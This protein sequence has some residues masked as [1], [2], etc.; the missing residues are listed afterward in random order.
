MLSS[1][2]ILEIQYLSNPAPQPYVVSIPQPRN[3]LRL[4][5]RYKYKYKASYRCHGEGRIVGGVPGFYVFDK[6]W[7]KS[8]EFY[9]FTDQ[10][11]QITLPLLT[12]I[13]SGSNPIRIRP[14]SESPVLQSSKQ[15]K[16][17]K[18]RKEVMR[19]YL[20]ETIWMNI[21]VPS[22]SVPLDDPLNSVME[23][24][25]EEDGLNRRS[26]IAKQ[27]NWEFHHYHFLAESLLGG[28]ASLEITRHIYGHPSISQEGKDVDQ[29]QALHDVTGHQYGYDVDREMIDKQWLVIPWEEEW[30]DQ[31]GLNEPIVSGLFHNHFVDSRKWNE[32]TLDDHWIGFERVVIVD[33][34]SSQ[35]HNPQAIQWNKMALDIFNLLP[36]SS[37]SS[38]SL[39][40]E[41]M[42]SPYRDKFLDYMDI[43]SL[44]RSKAGMA[45]HRLPK[46]VYLGY[47]TEKG[48]AE[49]VVGKLEEMKYK[50]QIGLFADADIIIGVHGN[51]LTHQ[52]WMAPGGMVIEIFPPGV[53]LRDYQL[54]AQV[55]GHE[56]IA[57]LNSRIYTRQEWENEPDKLLASHPDEANDRNITLSQGFIEDLLYLKLTNYQVDVVK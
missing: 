14:S 36:S 42:F 57:I 10:P 45:L 16:A 25:V 13:S 37:A 19:C 7:Y 32:T 17:H 55:V 54:I 4:L 38:Q 49:C 28:I 35:M 40:V 24:L 23:P 51:G 22:F 9:I 39:E 44:H 43:Q 11:D 41:P 3:H 8:G 21:G 5:L 15:R 33:R 46:I 6:I 34:W 56:H 26:R 48:I 12:A 52:M 30:K 18:E 50:D 53:F 2:N 20:D 47:L 31:Y 27:F 1:F 29:Q